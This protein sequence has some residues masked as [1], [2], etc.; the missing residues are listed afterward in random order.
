MTDAELI[1][2]IGNEK[3]IVIV[4]AGEVGEY[5]RR[6]LKKTCSY[7][8]V[9]I[10][11]NA[12][13]K[14][15]KYKDFEVL[16]VDKTVGLFPQ[17]LYIITSR[18]HE[19]TLKKQLTE[20]GVFEENM[21]LGVTEEA[22]EYMTER[23]RAVNCQPLEKLQFEVDIVA[24]C[25]LNCRC[26]SQFSCIAEEE[27]ID[28]GEMER[29]FQRLS[30]LFQ[31]EVGHLYLIGGEPLLHPQINKCMHIARH[32]FPLGKIAVFTNGLLLLKVAEAFWQSCR[33]NRITIIV[34]KYP[35]ELDYDWIINKAKAENVAFEF[36]GS[37]QDYKYMT[38]LGLDLEGRQD[39]AVSFSNCVE[40][41]NCIKLSKGR[42][43]TCTRPVAIHRF[44][45]YF[46]KHLE[47]SENDSIDIY[48]VDTKEEILKRLAEP[49]PF[50][51]YCDVLGER[52][53]MEWG[54]T[55]KK[56]EEWL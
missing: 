38:N 43:Y 23:K 40:A 48:K 30:I 18:I 56:I 16:S 45:N 35:I 53:A 29:D 26:C 2:N 32:Y 34:T 9:A 25:N 37:S 28:I 21:L 5:L 51:R 47:V 11:D 44:N 46:E 12:R 49:I 7:D 17:A 22:Q 13:K 54:Q 4:G 50:C 55:Q 15:K 52:K 14:Q 6:L 31:G 8:T 19:F 36:F 42:L 1:K 24:H 3:E 27:F 20:L 33:E 41:N 10:C 39:I